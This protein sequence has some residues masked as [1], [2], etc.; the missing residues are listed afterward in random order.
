MGPAETPGLSFGPW[1]MGDWPGMEF[2]EKW[3]AEHWR[4]AFKGNLHEVPEFDY[5]RIEAL[6]RQAVGG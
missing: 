2:T 3:R 4:L 5:E 6:I 1:A